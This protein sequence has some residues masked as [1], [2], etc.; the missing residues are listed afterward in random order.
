MGGDGGRLDGGDPR[1]GDT[2]DGDVLQVSALQAPLGWPSFRFR[3]DKLHQLLVS[4][5]LQVG[6][7]SL[8]H[9]SQI[10]PL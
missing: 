9:F 10:V 5:E 8:C 6:L 7:P 1:N 3:V 2:R 4:V